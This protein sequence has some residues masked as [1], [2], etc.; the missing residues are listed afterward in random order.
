MPTCCSPYTPRSS[1][2][3][4][5]ALTA[6]RY[7][8][9]KWDSK[10][11]HDVATFKESAG[12]HKSQKLVSSDSVLPCCHDTTTTGILPSQSQNC[13]QATCQPGDYI[14]VAE[15]WPGPQLPSTSA[16]LS[17]DVARSLGLPADGSH[18]LMYSAAG[19]VIAAGSCMLLNCRA[20]FC[21]TAF[22]SL[23]MH[24]LL[25]G[26]LRG[27]YRAESNHRVRWLL[28]VCMLHLQLQ[29]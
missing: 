25:C 9:I 12:I 27:W 3:T 18:L 21:V 16:C 19:G 26:R 13:L 6:T 23:C 17:P 11:L 28:S 2:S 15:A 24:I 10:V 1:I 20:G 29:A 5:C 22:R 7:G 4:A 8:V 14:A